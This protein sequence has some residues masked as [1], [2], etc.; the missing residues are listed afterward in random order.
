MY[1]YMHFSS[2]GGE[3]SILPVISAPEQDSCYINKQKKGHKW[4]AILLDI[5][6]SRA[7]HL[8]CERF[9]PPRLLLSFAELKYYDERL[10]YTRVTVFLGLIF[11]SEDGVYKWNLW[12]RLLPNWAP[13]VG[14]PT[15]EGFS[16]RSAHNRALSHLCFLLNAWF[17]T[18]CMR[19][20]SDP[21]R[22]RYN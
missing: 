15:S 1:V 13:L 10:R 5:I 22:E 2:K 20:I 19:Q 12:I 6:C 7:V 17:L 14:T 3:Y 4:V 16:R 11:L 21:M 18:G 8:I 9:A